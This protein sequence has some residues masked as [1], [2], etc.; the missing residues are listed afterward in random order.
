V[1][2]LGLDHLGFSTWAPS[3]S[4]VLA[5]IPGRFEAYAAWR[6][7]HGLPVEAGSRD[8]EIAGRRAGDEILFPPDLEPARAEDIGLAI[9]LLACSRADLLAELEAAPEAAFD[10]D[11]PYARFASWAD[12]RTIRA[13]LAHLAN[14]ETHY[15][16]RSIGYRSPKPP[17]GPADDWRVFLPRS[18]AETVSFL[19]ELA[20]SGDLCRV[21]TVDHGRGEE[22]WS[23]RKVLRR[24]LG[25]E[26]VHSKSIARIIREHR[27]RFPTA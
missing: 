4:E 1:V 2:A 6:S 12:W 19:E 11:P 10:W 15:Y 7:R 25:H 20:S 18:R 24:L 21:G 23:V 13:N 22:A 5:R 17:V 14:G 8:V 9:R 27:A 16:T 3:A 26:L